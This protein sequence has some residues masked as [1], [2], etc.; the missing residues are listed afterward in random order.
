MDESLYDPRVLARRHYRENLWLRDTL[1]SVAQELE[2]MAAKGQGETD[3][4]SWPSPANG[5]AD[6]WR[7][8]SLA[9]PP[10]LREPHSEFN[11]TVALRG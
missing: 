7:P 6:S 4:P 11:A 2:R 5:L 3:N 1:E 10:R 8:W 9:H